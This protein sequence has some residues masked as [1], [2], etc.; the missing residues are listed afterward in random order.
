VRDGSAVQALVDEVAGRH[1]RLDVMFN[2]AGI[3]IG[4]RTDEMSRDHWDRV[5]DVNLKGVVN[6]VVAAYPLMVSQGH[7]HIV[8]TASGAGLAP[9]VL[10][11]AYSASKHA[12]VGLTGALRAEAAMFGV[13]VTVL[14]PGAVDT[15]ILDAPPPP[16][17]PPLAT[18]V[19]TGR[20]YMA[21]VGLEPIPTERF[22]RVALRG[23]ARNRGMIVTPASAKAVWFLQRLSPGLVERVGRRTAR[24]ITRELATRPEVTRE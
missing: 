24:R 14:C 23:I 5:I 19:M 21:A 12:V 2:N 13:R 10:V 17:L 15:P 4:G 11:A 8:N 1:G 22:V 20:E 6:G 9:A 3:V 16:D 18:A 7:G